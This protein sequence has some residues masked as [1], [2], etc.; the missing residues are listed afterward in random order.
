MTCVPEHNKCVAVAISKP[1]VPKLRFPVPLPSD[2]CPVGWRLAVRALKSLH[3]DE[4]TFC[5]LDVEGSFL[6]DGETERTAE[7]VGFSHTSFDPD[8]GGVNARSLFAS[9]GFRKA[10][11]TCK[12][13][14]V[15]SS[16]FK[17]AWEDA[18]IAAGH[19]NLPVTVLPIPVYAERPRDS[20][21]TT[22]FMANTHRKIIQVGT[23]R[24]KT[25][26]I[27][28]LSA[29]RD[30][31]N[32]GECVSVRKASLTRHPLVRY[33][34]RLKGAYAEV[35]ATAEEKAFVNGAL[36]FAQLAASAVLPLS[37]MTPGDFT[38]LFA[39]NVF[40]L[41]LH[42]ISTLG[43]MMEAFV[44]NCPVLVNR[45]P[46]TV[47]LLGPAYPLFFDDVFTAADVLTMDNIRKAHASL[48]GR[49]KQHYSVEAFV[50][51][52]ANTAVYRNLPLLSKVVIESRTLG[53]Y[54]GA[55]VG[56]QLPFAG[57]LSTDRLQN[58]RVTAAGSACATAANPIYR[59]P[60]GAHRDECEMALC[61]VRAFEVNHS[62]D[63]VDHMD[64]FVR[65]MTEAGDPE[66]AVCCETT[67]QS[68]K[69]Y[70]A[71]KLANPSNKANPYQ[72]LS[73]CPDD[74]LVADAAPLTRIFPLILWCTSRPGVARRVI[75]SY[76]ELTHGSAECAEAAIL[77]ANVG[78]GLFYGKR[79][80]VVLAG[81]PTLEVQPLRVPA[82]SSILLGDYMLKEPQQLVAR[83]SAA[84]VLECALWALNKSR[85]FKSGMDLVLA[86]DPAANEASTLYGFLAGI[87]YGVDAMPQR[88]RAP[89]SWAGDVMT[90]AMLRAWGLV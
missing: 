89:A 67:R 9:E 34:P 70:L 90:S 43:V 83:G 5:D 40:F 31:I 3:C 57:A 85:D 37:P 55:V 27:A 75:Q 66:Q 16:H 54:L 73:R 79:R 14:F 62:F 49:E 6:T 48:A 47:E 56:N 22:K 20:F 19:P 1:V 10:L 35:Q 68:A 32:L 24:R 11:A 17:L 2:G 52:F 45:T 80:E 8:F 84:R 18:L 21:T 33:L 28:A 53:G 13:L 29:G 41:H 87:L 64:R 4:G 74:R 23:W 86:L 78:L 71:Q 39:D 36:D 58:Y 38:S 72:G 30:V 82:V 15:F 25:Y 88:W 12:G 59:W 63:P 77:L 42:D 46:F 51:S 7:W 26:G 69:R 81:E 65:W 60:A 61:S 44:R 50:N 76:V